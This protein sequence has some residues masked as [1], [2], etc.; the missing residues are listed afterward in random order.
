MS[1]TN[2]YYESLESWTAEIPDT[3]TRAWEPSPKFKK[4]AISGW[5]EG[6]KLL[7]AYQ[8]EISNIAGRR[9][10]EPAINWDV[11]GLDY[12]IGSYLVGQPDCWYDYR[13][14]EVKH[15]RVLFNASAAGFCSNRAI[16]IRG[17]MLASL[18]DCLER[19]H[20]RVS[21]DM[22]YGNEQIKE[23]PRV[24]V[25]VK[26][27]LDPLDV[28]RVAFLMCNP[29]CLRSLWFAFMEHK[30]WNSTGVIAYHLTPEDK[31]YDVWLDRLD[32][33]LNEIQAIQWVK[34]QLVK[35][36]VELAG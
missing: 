26:R 2:L 20:Y 24:L 9:I 1:K 12:D 25:C 28:D 17:A 14:P 13:A 32:E 34:S 21:V 16:Q 35:M 3:S 8:Y 5:T 11:T 7:A 30:G 36:G 18:V 31:L 27:D 15:V 33:D 19:A 23:K 10:Q 29:M 6:T 22:I 4:L